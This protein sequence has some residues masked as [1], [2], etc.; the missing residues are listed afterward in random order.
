MKILDSNKITAQSLTSGAQFS[1]DYSV[2]NI[3]DDNPRKCFMANSA[4]ATIS[5]T[6]ESGMS[7]VFLS[8]VM[9]D[10]LTLNISDTDNSLSIT[11][12]LDINNYSTNKWLNKNNDA[13][14]KPNLQPYTRG[15][16][17][18]TVL[19][20][21]ITTDT[22]LSDY[23]TGAPDTLVLEANLTLGNGGADL[24]ILEL[25]LSDS[26]NTI[27]NVWTG[28]SLGGGTA[29]LTLETSTDL[30]ALPV[31]GNSIHQWDQ[32]SGATGRFEDSSGNAI[33]VFNHSNIHV[34]SIITIGGSDYQVNQIVGDGTGAADI[35]L[36]GS[37]ADATITSVKN[38][39][40]IG[41][42][43]ASSVIAIE[44]P[45]IGISKALQD[46]SIRK[47]LNN[48]GY[49]ETQKN[50]INI[51]TCN[52]MIPIAQANNIIDFYHAYRSKPF[53]IQV[54]NDLGAAQSEAFNYSGFF[55]MID[56][57]EMVS[58]IHSGS[59]QNMTFNIREV[60]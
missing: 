34:G 41:I 8:G 33:N 39:V 32:S 6:L 7:A 55:Y 12:V 44:N 45:Q 36:S 28:D 31:E 47:P 27:E 48:G 10:S 30:K 46:F 53:P 15:T 58:A 60:V 43:Q 42:F 14:Q 13:K 51:F 50:L 37:V 56:P 2:D 38:P 11:D 20:S 57:P 4:S 16:F 18:G 49:Q 26:D 25:G 19:T 24:V 9:A 52:L 1:A 5:V 29:T 23:L 35:T 17:S 3:S 22:T 54:L 21:P 40:R 59:Y